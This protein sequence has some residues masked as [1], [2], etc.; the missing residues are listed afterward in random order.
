M[1]VDSDPAD[2]HLARNEFRV[3]GNS[4]DT[5]HLHP[6]SKTATA[7]PVSVAPKKVCRVL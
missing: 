4:D 1:V 6:S 5:A 2:G 7:I 3:F